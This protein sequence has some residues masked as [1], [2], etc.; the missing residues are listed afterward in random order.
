VLIIAAF[1]GFGKQNQGEV[2]GNI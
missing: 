1:S 2:I